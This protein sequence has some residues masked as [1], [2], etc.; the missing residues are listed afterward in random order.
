M[1]GGYTWSVSQSCEEKELAFEF[2]TAMMDN[3]EEI[4]SYMLKCGQLP[5]VDVSEAANYQELSGRPFAEQ[6]MEL[7]ENAQ[8]R[9]H[10]EKYSEISTY[11]SQMANSVVC[12]AEPEEA[13]ET[14]SQ[15]VI[16]IVGEEGTQSLAE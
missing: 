7:L 4:V 8:Y 14:Y 12:G 15:A 6:S 10:H 16:S 13:L 11:L 3:K 2:I 9:P 1:S 5:T